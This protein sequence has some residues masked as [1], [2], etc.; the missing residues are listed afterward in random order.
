MRDP[1]PGVKRR[2]RQASGGERKS[3]TAEATLTNT[4]PYHTP[5]DYDSMLRCFLCSSIS[6]LHL[7][8]GS[9]LISFLAPCMPGHTCIMFHS[10]SSP[11][12]EDTWLV[13]A[14]YFSITYLISWSFVEWNL[15]I[16]T[17][18]VEPLCI[19]VPIPTTV[20]IRNSQMHFKA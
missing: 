7:Y 9:E 11:A 15:K 13:R 8:S 3:H 2:K 17:V 5:N 1:S 19:R 4:Q 20:C 18:V 6:C 14:R 16:I 10:P 12:N